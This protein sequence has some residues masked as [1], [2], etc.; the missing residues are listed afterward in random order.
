MRSFIRRK[1]IKNPPQPHGEAVILR[2]QRVLDLLALLLYR[3]SVVAGND[4]V[5]PRKV[6]AADMPQVASQLIGERIAVALSGF[7]A[8]IVYLPVLLDNVLEG[9]A[10]VLAREFFPLVRGSLIH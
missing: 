6:L 3:E 8:V 5:K 7:V 2:G 1:R 10:V 4:L 9:N